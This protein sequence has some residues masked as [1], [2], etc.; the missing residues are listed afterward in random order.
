MQFFDLGDTDLQDLMTELAETSEGKLSNLTEHQEL[1]LE[2][3]MSSTWLTGQHQTALYETL[4]GSQ[5]GDGF[6]D[7]VF[8]FA[9]K[10]I[11]RRVRNRL[12]EEFN[13][14]EMD[15]VEPFD[16][17]C[18]PVVWAD[19]LAI[20]YRRKGAHALVGAMGRICTVLFQ[21]CLKHG[22]IPNL[23]KGKTGLLLLLK[24][25]GSK[26]AKAELFNANDPKLRISDVPSDFD[27]VTLVHTYRHLGTRVHI[28]QKMFPE[29]KARCG[30][31]GAT[32]RKYKKQLFKNPRISLH[33]RLFLF[34]SLVMSIEEFNLGTW[35]G[36]SKGEWAYL[37]KRLMSMYR[38]IA[39]ATVKEEGLFGEMIEFLLSFSYHLRRWLSTSLGFGTWSPG[40]AT[41]H[42]GAF[43][44]NWN[45]RNSTLSFCISASMQG[46]STNF[47]GRRQQITTTKMDLSVAW[48]VEWSSKTEQHGR[49]TLS[50]PMDAE[51][52][53]EGWLEAQ[54]VTHA[55][56]STGARPVFLHICDTVRDAW[57]MQARPMRSSFPGL[58][59]TE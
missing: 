38:A 45:G 9:F 23:K 24:G 14:Q 43:Q 27:F 54:D 15:M 39:R 5:P 59:I 16:S 56:K 6:A 13:I 26:A 4:A 30:Q 2:E 40:Q 34:N 8:G 47:H 28:G 33:K 25:E 7:L 52:H 29:I 22:L 17:E 32:F 48:L 1:L 46:G 42:S 11:M 3:I 58:G 20:A 18:Q 21:E 51:T 50:E 37:R 12:A 49:C 44:A 10:R 53:A 36:L 41:W 35:S 31:A 19:D 55:P 57:S